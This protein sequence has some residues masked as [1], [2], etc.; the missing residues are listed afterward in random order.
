MTRVW[1]REW[2]LWRMALSFFTRFPLAPLVDFQAADQHAAV[3]Y[4]PLIG[5]L[6]GACTAL[7]YWLSV[8]IL[9]VHLAVLLSMASTL[10]ITG[11]FHEDGLADTADGLGG[12][13]N[14]EQ[15]LTIMKDSRIG[16]FGAVALVMVLLGKFQALSHVPPL[17]IP[18][19]LIAAHAL[20]RW[21]AVLVIATQEY[22]RAEGKS[23]AY[24]G[25]L[26]PGALM[27][28]TGFGLLPLA[29]LHPHF[30]WA[31]LP[32]AA[33][34]VWFSVMLKNRLG[35]YSGDCLGAM[36]QLTEVIFYV[37][38]VALSGALWKSI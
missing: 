9:P 10:Y 19:V 31:L 1:Q 37:A 16:S 23:S 8:Q 3:K 34:W 32:V 5:I 27:L 21:C 14:R 35:G 15:A 4:L 25:R 38:V 22:V 13:W 33:V 12:G 20:S 11:V 18:A 6:V 30:W 2:R 36:Q 26:P 28:A 17:L 24:V 7:V 29:W